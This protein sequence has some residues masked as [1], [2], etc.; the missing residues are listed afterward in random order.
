MTEPI[1]RELSHLQGL[2]WQC[3]GCGAE[4]R[5]GLRL[6]IRLNGDRT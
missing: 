5:L 4:N 6:N 2:H 3:F 1:T